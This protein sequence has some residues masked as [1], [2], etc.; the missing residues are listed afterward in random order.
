MNPA[1]LALIAE[2]AIDAILVGVDRKL[3]RKTIATT[4]PEDIPAALVA[5][6]TA[7]IANAQAE[8]DKEA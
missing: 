3:V 1:L 5:L 8:I 7:A 4:K 2:R 6:R